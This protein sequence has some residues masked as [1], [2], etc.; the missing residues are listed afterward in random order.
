MPSFVAWYKNILYLIGYVW[1][2]HDGFETNPKK[3][4]IINLMVKEMGNKNLGCVVIEG[5]I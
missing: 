4:F 1:I 2:M 3:N 5:W